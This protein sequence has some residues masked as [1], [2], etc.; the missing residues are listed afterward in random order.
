MTPWGH[1]SINP[2]APWRHEIPQ[3]L[4]DAPGSTISSCREVMLR[5]FSPSGFNVNSPLTLGVESGF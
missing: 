4:L 2:L 3:N 1:M 5:V